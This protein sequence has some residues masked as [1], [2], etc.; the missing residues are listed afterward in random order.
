[1]NLSTAAKAARL[2]SSV[3]A[4]T[5]DVESASVDMTGFLAV[6]VTVSLGAITAGAVTSVKLQGSDDDTTFVDL[7]GT[8]VTVAD[9]ADE[10]VVI[11]DCQHPQHQYVRA[12]VARATQN[13]AVDS[14]T[15]RQYLANAE[16][17]THDDT[18]AS[19]TIIHAPVEA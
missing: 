6:E 9:D 19:S 3:V 5:T 17:V 11:I 18:V 4:G 12:V 1:M 8:E 15:S 13:S 10:K 2:S 7:A 14:I 16:P